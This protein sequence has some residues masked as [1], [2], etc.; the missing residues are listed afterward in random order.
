MKKEGEGGLDGT[1]EKEKVT[2][3]KQWML[4]EI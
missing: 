2:R 4:G 1:K 3:G